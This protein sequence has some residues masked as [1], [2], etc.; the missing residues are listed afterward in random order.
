MF[1]VIKHYKKLFIFSGILTAGSLILIFTWGLKAGI[2]F[3]GGTLWDVE[4][5]NI[6]ETTRLREDIIKQGYNPVI[7]SVNEKRLIIK[8]EPQTDKQQ[9]DFRAF[10]GK[11]FGQF[12][13]H[14][15]ESIG[16][17][18]GRELVSK[19][20]W[21]IILV[22]LGIIL[23]ISYS[24]RKIGEDARK[25]RLSSWKLGA[26]TVIALI[27]DLIVTVGVF[28]V[29]G[30]FRGV[31]IDNLFVTALLTILG[32]S[33]H[34]TIVVFD[35]IRENLKKFP[36]KPLA[37]LI[38]YSI[39]TTLARSINTS[40]TLIFMLLALLL[41]GGETVFYFVLALLVGVTVGTYSSVFIATPVLYLWQKE[42]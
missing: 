23:Y 14:R 33:V 15:F 39:N 28:A 21:Q 38:D 20:Y 36:Y 17:A 42:R 24:F 34:D 12:Q 18:I 19:A 9:Q 11:E 10:L 3:R 2:D 16:P 31:E 7:Q 6:A 27:H 29:L 26:A 8:T 1:S 5:Q 32:F 30:H 22:C 41:F 35:R 13:E 25:T 4:F 40:S 37:S